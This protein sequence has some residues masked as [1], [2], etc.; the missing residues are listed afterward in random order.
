MFWV[1][2]ITVSANQ[3]FCVPTTYTH[4][5]KK[6]TLSIYNVCLICIVIRGS[7]T[8]TIYQTVE[9]NFFFQ[10]YNAGIHVPAIWQE[11]VFNG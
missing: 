6:A 7:L 9:N 3:L 8:G 10:Q 2:N 11:T 4:A 5:K 1:L